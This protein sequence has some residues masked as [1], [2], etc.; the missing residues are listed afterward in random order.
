MRFVTDLSV[1]SP[2]R[3]VGSVPDAL[4]FDLTTGLPPAFGF[5]RASEATR[6]GPAGTLETV[7]PDVARVHFDPAGSGAP[8]GLLIEAARTN[9]I[10]H[11]R[12]L[13]HA[14]W[15]AFG[16]Q[17]ARDA[18]GID[19][20]PNTA[21]TLADNSS[22]IGANIRQG[23]T[24]AADMSAHAV[25]AFFRKTSGATTFPALRARILG[26]S[27]LDTELHVD[28][29]TG[30]AEFDQ[31]LNA[32]GSDIAVADHGDWWRASFVIRNNGTAGNTTLELMLFGAMTSVIGMR[33]TAVTGSAVID[34]VQVETHAAKVSS[35]IYTTT[36]PVT[37]A[38]DQAAL[39]ADIGLC[40]VVLTYG[41]GSTDILP[42]EPVVAGWWPAQRR[43]C[44]RWIDLHAPGTV[45]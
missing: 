33:D 39:L 35:Y 32:G 45:A 3:S 10:T 7:A 38:A 13:T 36:V 8:L 1:L 41:D 11:S 37:R 29:D 22:G 44:L 19:G 43:A 18:T 27:A 40:D 25:S 24:I 12:D 28:T 26:G 5:A 6:T 31:S 21:M 17:V 34:G 4:R 30:G 42:G 9:V 2:R 15:N 16:A 20:Q 14:S 23:I